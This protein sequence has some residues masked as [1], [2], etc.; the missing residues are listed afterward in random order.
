MRE[1]KYRV[2]NSAHEWWHDF[3]L[4]ELIGSKLGMGVYENFREYTGLKDKNGVEIYEGDIV[5][6]ERENKLIEIKPPN[7]WLVKKR[8]GRGSLLYKS[9]AKYYKVIGNIYEN[10]ELCNG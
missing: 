4:E 7:F 10:P 3:T 8:G 5:V 1:R 6:S 2:W 9:L